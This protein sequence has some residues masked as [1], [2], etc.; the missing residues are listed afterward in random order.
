MCWFNLWIWKWLMN[1]SNS[2]LLVQCLITSTSR[3]NTGSLFSFSKVNL[4]QWNLLLSKKSW[5]CE[6][7]RRHGW[8]KICHQSI[9]GSNVFFSYWKAE[10]LKSNELI[11]SSWYEL[12]H[13]F[14]LPFYRSYQFSSHIVV[15]NFFHI[16]IFHVLYTH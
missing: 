7:Y 16:D 3:K 6:K 12:F 15:F 5:K 10:K 1:K 14:N 9:D 8:I 13:L 11:D 2:N 4:I